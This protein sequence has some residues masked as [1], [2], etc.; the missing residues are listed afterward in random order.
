MKNISA[1]LLVYMF[2]YMYIVG[3]YICS[4]RVYMLVTYVCLYFTGEYHVTLCLDY[5][6]D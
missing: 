3:A 1:L 5:Y 6:K 4:F 2:V